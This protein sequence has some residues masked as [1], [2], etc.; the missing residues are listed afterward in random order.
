MKY[1]FYILQLNQTVLNGLLAAGKL[2]NEKEKK[3]E[4]P[5]FPAARFLRLPMHGKRCL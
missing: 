4:K 2:P 5:K 1:T 3:G